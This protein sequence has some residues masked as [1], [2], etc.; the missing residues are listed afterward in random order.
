MRRT[1]KVAAVGLS[2]LSLLLVGGIV[3]RL[4]P[5][6]V[7]PGL[8]NSP[9]STTMN[10]T[11]T[12]LQ[13]LIDGKFPTASD[14]QGT[15]GVLVTV[16]GLEVLYVRTE[17]D[18]DWH[19]AVSDGKV[20]VFITEITPSYQ[21]ALG[22]PPVGSVIDETGVPFCDTVHETESWHGNTC[23]E[24]HPVTSWH[25]SGATISARVANRTP[26][27]LSV[28]ISYAANPIQR[29]ST[30]TIGVSLHDSDGPIPNAVTS[31][32]V[33]YASGYTVHNFSCTTSTDGS[34]S[35]TWGIGGTSTPGVFNVIVELEG[36]T[37]YSSFV[38]VS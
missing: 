14:K 4:N 32:E 19:V 9:H 34:C 25:L 23:W 12:T 5:S 3:Y 22:E 38:V 7:Q 27:P 1:I 31:I 8:T 20:Q 10:G 30:Q 28:T 24:I 18:G 36:Q 29:G 37:F 6:A 35:A 16:G 11:V 15:G 13:D 21:S 2:A 26:L 33:N 17:S